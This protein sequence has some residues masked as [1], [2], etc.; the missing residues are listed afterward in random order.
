MNGTPLPSRA[1]RLT[2][3]RKERER[4]RRLRAREE[5]AKGIPAP[6]RLEGS[7]DFC[8]RKAAVSR[9]DGSRLCVVCLS[10]EQALL[11]KSP[12]ISLLAILILCL[13][14]CL[15]SHARPIPAGISA[16]G[17][18]ARTLYA[19]AR[20]ESEAGIRAVASVIWN[21]AGSGSRA[22]SPERL[23]EVCLRP[24]QFSAWNNGRIPPKGSG[25]AWKMCEKIAREMI[26]GGFSPGI[27]ARH[28]YAPKRLA[29]PPAWARGR[30]SFDIGN[31]RFVEGVK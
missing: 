18:I 20:G 19:E 6:R 12:R 17:V 1:D 29:S 9:A 14:S 23:A 13:G 21:R 3:R 25:M 26:S 2:Y 30:R 24:Y 5:A 11:R 28:Y 27:S 8:D 16:E 7:C 4:K 22:R 31:H 10:E 15:P